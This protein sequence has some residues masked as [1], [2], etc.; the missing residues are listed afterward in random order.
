MQSPQPQTMSVDYGAAEADGPAPERHDQ[1]FADVGRLPAFTIELGGLIN[2][3]VLAK[4]NSLEKNS[5]NSANSRLG[6]RL[7]SETQ[8]RSLRL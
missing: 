1:L 7:I 2:V 5:K 4:Q 8:R 3:R 6:P